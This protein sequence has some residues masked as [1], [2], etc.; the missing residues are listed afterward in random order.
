MGHLV[1][2][3]THDAA[4]RGAGAAFM[5]AIAL[6][7]SAEFGA[8]GATRSALRAAAL[9]CYVAVTVLF[10][11]VFR[12][13]DRRWALA[14]GALSIGLLVIAPLRWHPGGVD[15]GLVCFGLACLA[16]AYLVFRSGF[17][18][19][20][21]AACSAIAGVAWLTFLWQPLSRSVYPY[22]LAVG[23]LG[24]LALC[25]WLAVR[26]THTAARAGARP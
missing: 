24:Q 8:H 14:A 22:N 17:V 26:G 18:P 12:G 19:R 23:I 7:V 2:Q 25:L 5:A 20:M 13:V 9:L 1:T 15:V 6:G 21:L 10:Y 4:A 11:V 3:Q 16:T